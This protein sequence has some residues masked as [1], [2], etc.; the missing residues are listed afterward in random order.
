M[1]ANRFLSIPIFSVLLLLGFVY[2]FTVFIFIEDWVGLQTSQGFLNA[3]I[4]TVL[5]FL[6]LFSFF[7]CVSSDP[8]RVPPSY[9]PDVE[10]DNSADQEAKRN[11]SFFFFLIFF[12]LILGFWFCFYAGKMW[13]K[14]RNG[15]FELKRKAPF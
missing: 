10:D 2:Y 9:V 1:K 12:L 14:R 7:V 3:L 6:S 8:G 15:N 4:F 13:G 11:V 5:A